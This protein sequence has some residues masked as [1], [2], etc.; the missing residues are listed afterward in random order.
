MPWLLLMIYCLKC[1]RCFG[2]SS[3]FQTLAALASENMMSGETAEAAFPN[4]RTRLGRKIIPELRLYNGQNSEN[5]KGKPGK[6]FP[7]L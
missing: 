5:H 6:F 4:S 2:G 7:K 1:E 3:S